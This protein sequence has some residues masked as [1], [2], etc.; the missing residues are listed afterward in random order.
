MDSNLLL[1]FDE[2]ISPQSKVL[3]SVWQRMGAYAI[4]GFLMNGIFALVRKSFSKSLSGDEEFNSLM[5]YWLSIR[6][7]N[8]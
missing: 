7:D 5:F 3:A 2:T 4:D 6:E 1:D 8:F